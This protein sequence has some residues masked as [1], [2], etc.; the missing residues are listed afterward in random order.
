[1]SKARFIQSSFIQS[2]DAT[3]NEHIMHLVEHETKQIPKL[4]EIRASEGKTLV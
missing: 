3:L 4:P 2:S 1:M